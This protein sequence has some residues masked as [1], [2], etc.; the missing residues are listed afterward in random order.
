MPE[1]EIVPVVT[2]C[3]NFANELNCDVKHDDE[4]DIWFVH[5]KNE[6]PFWDFQ[7]FEN[8]SGLWIEYIPENSGGNIR[9]D[10]RTNNSIVAKMYH[11][12]VEK[13]GHKGKNT[14]SHFEKL[15]K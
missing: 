8:Q 4:D 2:K 1:N 3:Y 7:I 13:F 6:K 15:S 9:F 11:E 5:I 12:L 10:G 14:I